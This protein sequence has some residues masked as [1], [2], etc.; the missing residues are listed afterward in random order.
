LSIDRLTTNPAFGFSDAVTISGPGRVIHV[1]GSVGFAEDGTVV[2]G[3]MEAEARATFANIEKTLSAAGATMA[4]VIKI[5]AFITDLDA[6][7]AYA[8]VRSEVFG[9]DTLPA[10]STVQVAGLLVGAQIEL[11]AIAFLPGD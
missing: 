5:S 3:G 6:Y 7:P 4:D 10:S 1:S 2:S 11:E 9:A 8:K